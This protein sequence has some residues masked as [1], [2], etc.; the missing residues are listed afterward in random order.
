MSKEPRIKAACVLIAGLLFLFLF[1]RSDYQHLT[2][3][4]DQKDQIQ[5]E[6]G[7]KGNASNSGKT[8]EAS[9]GS[10]SNDSN[11]EKDPNKDSEA[12]ADV[13]SK[14]NESDTQNKNSDSGDS[15]DDEDMKDQSEI[16]DETDQRPD[17]GNGNG[18]ND[19]FDDLPKIDGSLDPGTIPEPNIQD[20]NQRVTASLSEDEIEAILRTLESNDYT[21]RG[22][23]CSNDSLFANTT[24]S[25]KNSITIDLDQ[26]IMTGTY[27]FGSEPEIMKHRYDLKTGQGALVNI[28]RKLYCVSNKAKETMSCYDADGDSTSSVLDD[29]L[30][31]QYE[32]EIDRQLARFS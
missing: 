27:Y 10:S 12:E 8:N 7:S 13:D 4:T 5:T 25:K 22:N 19:L 26:M 31:A 14:T 2:P 17:H 28:T 20:M 32:Q 21:C 24:S 11:P 16:P 15:I 30:A 3:S 29:G 9:K 23:I 1:S 6:D 18:S